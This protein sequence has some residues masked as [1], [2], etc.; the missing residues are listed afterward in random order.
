MQVKSLVG[1]SGT[2]KSYKA[3]LV[4][5]ENNIEYLIDDGLFIKGNKIIAGA[6]AKKEHTRI[7]AVRRALF[8]DLKHRREVIR[9]IEQHKPDSMLILGTSDGMVDKI[10]GVLGIPSPQTRL[11]I[12]DIASEAEIELARQQRLQKGKHIIP[13]PTLEVK[14]DF[15]GYFL[16]TLR[17][18]SKRRDDSI[19]VDEKTV[20]RP[21]YSYLGKYTIYGRAI[22][23]IAKAAAERIDGI[24]RIHNTEVVVHPQGIVLNTDVTV[25]YGI[26]MEGPVMEMKNAVKS[27]IEHMTSL[28]VLAINVTVKGL[29]MDR[30]K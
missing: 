30:G 17:I 3:L 8:T 22:T 16:D 12:E 6:S 13:V 27:E 7:A 19:T 14:K 5:K 4:A 2:G 26:V 10:T 20:V 1:T 25:E 28:N 23:Q 15:S 24:G 9:A 18:F 21:T 11:Y 29:M